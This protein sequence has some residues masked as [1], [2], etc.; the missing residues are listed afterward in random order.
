MDVFRPARATVAA[1]VA[2]FRGRAYV[3]SARRRHD[4]RPV[5]P[6]VAGLRVIF[7]VA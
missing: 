6:G 2:L 5:G 1:I 7:R 4:C 3:T